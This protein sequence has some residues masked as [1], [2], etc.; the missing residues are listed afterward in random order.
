MRKV[1]FRV[2]FFAFSVYS[3]LFAVALLVDIHLDGSTAGY[4]LEDGEELLYCNDWRMAV[5]GIESLRHERRP[6]LFIVGGSVSRAF[7]PATMAQWDEKYLI[8]NFA[9]GSSNISQARELV[10]DLFSKIDRDCWESTVIVIGS[11]FWSL[12]DNRSMF[13]VNDGLSFYTTEK[14]RHGL[15]IKHDDKHTSLRVPSA[16][17][18][19]TI[20]ALKPVLLCYAVKYHIEIELKELIFKTIQYTLN[21]AHRTE[22]DT[23][24]SGTETDEATKYKQIC[25]IDNDHSEQLNELALLVDF[26]KKR[27]AT[28]IILDLPISN[29]IISLCDEYGRYSEELRRLTKDESVNFI[30]MHSALPDSDFRDGLHLTPD[31]KTKATIMLRERLRHVLQAIRGH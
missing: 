4:S 13:K 10:E 27:N 12:H 5:Y 25:S 31:A 6:Q 24:K 29:R 2:L 3:V 8:H 20:I 1:I 21:I 26:I 22:Y 17:Q 18:E 11:H 23:I 7:L 14:L 30:D 9:M 15:Y 19:I 16:L 28:I